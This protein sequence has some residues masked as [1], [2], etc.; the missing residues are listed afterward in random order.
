MPCPNFCTSPALQPRQ[1]GP[2]VFGD[3]SELIVRNDKK[4]VNGT[5][6]RYYLYDTGP[7]R[8]RFDEYDTVHNGFQVWAEQG[9]GLK[10]I[11]VFSPEEA[12][13]RIGF[14]KGDGSWSYIGRDIL[15]QASSQRT[16]NF[17]WDVSNDLDT[18]LHEIG[19]TLGFPHEHQNPNAGIQWNADEV[20]EALA[21]PPNYWDAETTE[22][23]I[24]SKLDPALYSGSNWDP[25]SVMHYP[26]EAGW[27]SRPTQYINTPLIPPGGLSPQDQK[28]A[29]SFYPPLR[30][31]NPV[32]APFRS[33]NA[34]LTPGQQLNYD[35][36]FTGTR[37]YQFRTLG[38]SDT[39]MVLFEEIDGE[40]R[41]CVSDDD[42]GADKNAYFKVKLYEGRQYVL[43][44]RLYWSDH[45]A[46]FG[47][48]YW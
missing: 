21:G 45:T 14:L 13:I 26:I 29:L 40:L 1:F 10:F 25:K 17:G 5:E 44:V 27:I 48:M 19:H 34:A 6:L 20:Y 37:E 18:V 4:W 8:S 3:R 12:E 36:S 28:T 43:R 38:K 2:E 33:K 24:L 22:H 23:N 9:I 32:L 35:L 31:S 42:S 30:K 7:W 41:H 11:P 16:M 15:R 39:V 47:V 46:N